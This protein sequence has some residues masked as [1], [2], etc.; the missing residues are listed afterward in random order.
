MQDFNRK[1]QNLKYRSITSAEYSFEGT[2]FGCAIGSNTLSGYLP[3]ATTAPKGEEFDRWT[4]D[5]SGITNVNAANT[6]L[7]IPA[8]VAANTP[9]ANRCM[10]ERKDYKSA[11]TRRARAK[12]PMPA[13]RSH[14]V[15]KNM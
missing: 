10:K 1:Y 5:I 3:G 15:G 9:F 12:F 7:T 2:T 13:R 11:R 4:G 8:R 6:T 14:W